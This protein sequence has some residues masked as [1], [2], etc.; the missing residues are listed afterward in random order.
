MKLRELESELGLGSMDKAW[1]ICRK[2]GISLPRGKGKER[3]LSADEELRFRM[4]ANPARSYRKRD[5]QIPASSST[6]EPE[7]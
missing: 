7:A 5:L 2:L 4:A 6:V 1:R 3:D